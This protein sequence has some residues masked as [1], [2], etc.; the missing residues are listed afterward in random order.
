MAINGWIDVKTQHKTMGGSTQISVENGIDKGVFIDLG[1]QYVY[2]SRKKAV[3]LVLAI[4]SATHDIETLD[5]RGVLWEV[6]K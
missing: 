2:L 5:I 3:R 4:L 6:K 1:E